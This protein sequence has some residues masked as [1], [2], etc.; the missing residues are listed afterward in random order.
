MHFASFNSFAQWVISACGSVTVCW[1][2]FATFLLISSLAESLFYKDYNQ[3]SGGFFFGESA[4]VGGRV[5][6]EG[7]PDHKL[8]MTKASDS[9]TESMK[10][11]LRTPKTLYLSAIWSLYNRRYFSPFKLQKRESKRVRRAYSCS[12]PSSSLALL[13][14]PR[15]RF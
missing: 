10:Q 11:F 7:P 4:K 13:S 3:Q 12:T 1:T 5:R 8:A 14:L 15:R 2:L 6:E 9:L